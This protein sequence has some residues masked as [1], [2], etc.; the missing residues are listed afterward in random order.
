MNAELNKKVLEYA[1]VTGRAMHLANQFAEEQTTKAAAARAK[2]AN[3]VSALKRAGL[4][5]DYQEKDAAAQL[6]NHESALA[7]LVNVV[8]EMQTK[9]ASV[10]GHGVTDPTASAA[11]S[12]TAIYLGRRSNEKRAS[13]ECLMRLIPGYGR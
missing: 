8:D 9:S 1:E 5:E 12:E 7:I 10:L 13:D 4:I 11:K 3:A 2:I 6:Q